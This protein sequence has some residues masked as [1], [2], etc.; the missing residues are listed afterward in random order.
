MTDRPTSLEGQSAGVNTRQ[1]DRLIQAV[2]ARDRIDQLI[3]EKLTELQEAG[4][5]LAELL[6]VGYGH[7]LDKARSLPT[8]A[9]EKKHPQGQDF[10]RQAKRVQ[11]SSSSST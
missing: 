7:R 11:L 2:E 5:N 4:K 1:V 3:R 8:P 9:S 6:D 10:D